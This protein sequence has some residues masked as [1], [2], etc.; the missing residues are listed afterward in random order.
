MMGGRIWVESEPGQGATV[1]FT[2][3]FGIGAVVPKTEESGILETRGKVALI[4]DDNRTNRRVL[5]GALQDF[6]ITSVSAASGIEA[7]DILE[8]RHGRLDLILLD[9]H[10]PEMDGFELARRIQER[11]SPLIPRM[12]MLCSGGQSG[13]IARCKDAGIETYLTKP[14]RRADLRTAIGALLQSPVQITAESAEDVVTLGRRIAGESRLTLRVL[15]AEDNVV[16]RKLIGRLLGREGHSVVTAVDG[17]QAVEAYRSGEFDVILMDI[18]MPVLD[19]FEATAAI[20]AND[21]AKGRPRIPI[22]ALTAHAMPRDR[23]RCL[24]AGM[25]DYLTKPIEVSKM[26]QALAK[27]IAA[28]EIAV[29][30]PI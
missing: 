6:G 16:N 13:D 17:A 7:L 11:F 4:V 25:D 28:A 18:Q 14:V 23:E 1:R 20:R 26:R 29:P 9:G 3:S 8:R 2:A 12:A 15:V 24:E 5:E 21:A 22:I 19:G 27:V 30:L 10:M